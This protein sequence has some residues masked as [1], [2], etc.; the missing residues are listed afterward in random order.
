MSL[1]D[2]HLICGTREPWLDDCLASLKDEPITLWPIDRIE[3][4]TA[5]ARERGFR[6]GTLPYVSF[7]DPD[8]MV[9]PGIFQQCADLLD[10]N[11]DLVGVYTD[12]LL[13]NRRGEYLMDGWSLDDTPFLRFG[14]RQALMQGIHHLHVLR[15]EVV[16]QCLPL[17]TKRMPEPVLMHELAQF[18]DLHHLCEVGY[19][20]R[21]HG[22][23]TFFSY[24]TDELDEAMQCV[25]AIHASD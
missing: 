3:G 24:T 7:V 10:E 15:R 25:E 16:E 6:C 21:I 12:E 2:V 13:V 18:G 19:F 20:W 5:A 9:V 11:P 22:K 23:N 8:D 1:V 4:D 17:K 14:Y